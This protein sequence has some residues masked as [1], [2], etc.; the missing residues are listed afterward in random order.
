[1]NQGDGTFRPKFDWTREAEDRG[2]EDMTPLFFDADG[3]GDLDLF[4]TSG[5]VE[6]P[7]AHPIYADRLYL[8]DGAANFRKAPA[9][10][11]GRPF[12]SGPAGAADFDRDGDLDL[13]VGGRVVPGQYPTAPGSRLLR[14]N[15]RGEFEDATLELAPALAETGMVTG[16]IW[17]DAD[18]D[19]W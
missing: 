5:G 12:S 14:N 18:N 15:G 1:L 11:P 7:P 10:I 2:C 19:G 3:D 13:F 16:A 6:A 9:A 4:V 8:N 17:S